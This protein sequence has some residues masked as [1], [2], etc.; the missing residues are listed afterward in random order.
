MDVCFA[1]RKKKGGGKKAQP[2]S[3]DHDYLSS[4]YYTTVVN[5]L[6]FVENLQDVIGIIYSF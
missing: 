3:V 6:A 4:S 5:G 2:L 1:D